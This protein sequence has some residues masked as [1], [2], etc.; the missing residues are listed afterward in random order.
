MRSP[1]EVGVPPAAERAPEAPAHDQSVVE[2]REQNAFHG[3]SGVPNTQ[4]RRNIIVENAVPECV[5]GPA[6]G[7]ILG[8]SSLNG[9][10]RVRSRGFWWDYSAL[11]SVRS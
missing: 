11:C 6:V 7:D 10:V 2:A 4:T 3:Y 8:L 9:R 5:E 1:R